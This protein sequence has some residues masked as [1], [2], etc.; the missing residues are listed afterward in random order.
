MNERR[1]ISVDDAYALETPEDNVDLYKRWAGTYDTE[2]A[3]A[4]GYILY[5]HVSEQLLKRQSQINGAVLDVGCG[6]GLVG[7]VLREAGI[8]SIDGIDISPEMLAQAASKTTADGDPVYR[9][10]IQADLTQTLDIP[11]DHYGALVSAGTFTHG[12]LG[13]ESLD[14]LW[15]VA[16]PGAVAV[17]GV[18]STHYEAM[19]FKAKFAA[20]VASGTITQPE[21]VM[22][23]VYG[24][25]ARNAEHADDKTH[26]V[27]GQVA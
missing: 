7:R 25:N 22:V 9:N 8:D 5:L 20:D 16:S 15:R 4:E 26:I 1:K 23:N 17:I 3:E 12:H 19:G 13:P 10:L 18:R 24:E 11:D 27:V 21:I 6:T 14:E 2:F